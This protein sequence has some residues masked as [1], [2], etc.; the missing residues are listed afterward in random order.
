MALVSPGLQLTVTDESQYVPAAVGSVP[1]VILA[2]AQDKTI[3]GSIAAGTTKANAG[4]LQA[5][6]SQRE[7]VS[8]L[9]YPTFQQSSAG[10]P[11][12]GDEL[13][14]YG[15]MA[16]YSTLALGNRVY[17]IRADID[18]NELTATSVRPTGQADNGT[19]WLDIA[20]TTWG[21]NQWTAGL[22]QEFSLQSPILITDTADLSSGVPLPS[23]GTIG[24][25]AVVV[26]QTENRVS[27][28]AG[29]GLPT[30]DAKYNTWV[31]VG[32]SN[33]QNSWPTISGTAAPVTLTHVTS[34][35]NAG[36]Y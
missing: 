26:A 23:I 22:T 3:N 19:F 31:N 11:L 18:L 29:A 35:P 14:E 1:L 34:G 7:L 5:F 17:A 9:G 13:N 15:L 32:T 24:S 6:T 8:A 2:T 27:Y 4:K 33:W 21:I 20:D 12:H 16:A 10:T 36:T 25:Y 28:K 30:D